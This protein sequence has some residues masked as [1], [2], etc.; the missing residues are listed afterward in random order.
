MYEAAHAEQLPDCMKHH[1]AARYRLRSNRLTAHHHSEKKLQSNVAQLKELLPSTTSLRE[2]FDTHCCKEG[3]LPS[4]VTFPQAVRNWRI[5]WRSLLPSARREQLLSLHAASLADHKLSNC[6]LCTW[7]VRYLFMGVHVC[8]DAFCALAGV[9]MSTLMEA[10]HGALR[11]AKSSL[12]LRELLVCQRIVNTNQKPLHLDARQ[13]LEYYADSHGEQSPMDCLTFLPGGRKQFYY[14]HFKHDRET[15]SRHAAG[16][17]TFMD[18]WCVDVNWLVIAKTISKF[19]KC[20]CCEDLKWLIDKCPR[21]RK[22]VLV[23]YLARL[24][25]H[26]AFQSAPRL[27]VARVEELCLQSGNKNGR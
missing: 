26:L 1:A 11:D 25:Q 13:W 10:R 2:R 7:K 4:F 3:C 12:S 9:G 17:S 22:P 21:H 18:A 19:S 5:L 24:G 23:M 27:V 14:S 6:L 15:Q 8:R 16:F 20:G